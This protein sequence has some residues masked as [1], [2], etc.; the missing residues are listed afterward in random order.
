M[1][2]PPAAVLYD[3]AMSHLAVLEPDWAE[4]RAI[5]DELIAEGG[6]LP[7]DAR[8]WAKCVMGLADA[9]AP[10]TTQP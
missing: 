4:A 6:G 3:C 9:P 1:R 2:T 5:L 7:D 10:R 8:A